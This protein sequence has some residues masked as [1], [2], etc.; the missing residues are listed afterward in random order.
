MSVVDQADISSWQWLVDGELVSE[1]QFPV[2]MF[3]EAKDYTVRLIAG[4]TK[5][6]ESFYEEVVTVGAAPD[7]GIGIELGCLGEP[8]VFTDL[9]D[10]GEVLTRSWMIDGQPYTDESP[11]VTF[12]EPGDYEVELTVTNN[13]LCSS[14]VT[15][16]FT[17]YE[18]PMP[19]LV[20]L[21]NV[22]MKSSCWKMNRS[23]LA[24]RSTCGNGI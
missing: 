2:I 24:I 23:A 1:E 18:L 22:T 15:E 10:P 12:N 5:G 13:Q 4:S 16:T 3:E 6:C 9:T 17:I 7:A 11:S 21:V 8:T 19:G 14:I 20:F